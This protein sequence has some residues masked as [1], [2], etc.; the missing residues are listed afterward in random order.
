MRIIGGKMGGTNIYSPKDNKTRPTTDRARESLFNIVADKIESALF[1]DLFAG[2]GAVG[3]EALSR[4]ARQ[5]T[6]VEK[7][8]IDLIAKN[9][10]KLKVRSGEELIVMR[11]DVF[12]AIDA[13]R[14]KEEKFDIIFADP[15]WSDGHEKKIVDE[16]VD[17]LAKNG[18]L[19][20]ETFSKQKMPE[21]DTARKIKLV[22]KKRY[23][24]TS[25]YFYNQEGI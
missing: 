15:P 21:K 24:D 1:L 23:G 16:S 12:V 4:G 14:Q 20:I 13:L 3:F 22:N 2:S 9:C 5:V 10:A 8:E 7:N 6:M 17:L 11:G 18:T 25:F 19:I